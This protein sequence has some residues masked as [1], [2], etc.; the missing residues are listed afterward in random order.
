LARKIC[1]QIN[2]RYSHILTYTFPFFN[3]RSNRIKNPKNLE[4]KAIIAKFV[5]LEEGSGQR[6]DTT[7]QCRNSKATNFVKK[8]AASKGLL[9]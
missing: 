9:S 2:T 1:R 5:L 7:H 6:G 3:F 4:V 8:K